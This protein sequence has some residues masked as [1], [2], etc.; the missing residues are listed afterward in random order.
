ML[1][2][3]DYAM[4]SAVARAAAE[5]PDTRADLE[6][7]G[8]RW[9]EAAQRA[10]LDGYAESAALA[11][12]PSPDSEARGVLELFSLEKALYE[13]SYEIDNRPDWSR[14]PLRGLLEILELQKA[15]EEP[16]KT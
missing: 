12:L 1:R 6:R 10:F 15:E 9:R 8:R 13:L 4:H 2:S 7:L 16:W 11:Q 5:R 14:I 3:F